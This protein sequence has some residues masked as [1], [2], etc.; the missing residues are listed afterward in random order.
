M[1]TET[2]VP[3]P[4]GRRRQ[5]PQGGIR[6]NLILSPETYAALDRCARQNGTSLSQEARNAILRHLTR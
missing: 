1:K 3:V 2:V 6:I 4:H 5:F